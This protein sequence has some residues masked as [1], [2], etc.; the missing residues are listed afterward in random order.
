M[1]GDSTQRFFSGDAITELPGTE[2]EIKNIAS[3]AQD[4]QLSVQKY[5]Y[6]DA[7][8]GRLKAVESPSILHVA[9]HGFFMN[10]SAAASADERGG[11]ANFTSDDLK[12]PLRRSGLL[13]S[14]CK[15]AFSRDKNKLI[16]DEDGILTA[17]EAQNLS[18][19]NTDMVVLSACETGLGEVKNGEGVYGLQR[20]FQTA[21]AKSVLMSLWTVSDQATQELMTEF[22]MQWFSLKD[23]KLAFRQA[24]L[25]LKKKYPDPFYWGAF[26]LVGD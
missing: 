12:N 4:N 25:N 7:T 17:D 3:I 24:Q 19:D 1:E 9:T 8:E 6:D 11:F 2:I 13:F 18:L 14:Y 5:L 23:K 20:A 10:E 26:V 22:Y 21:G 16:L 15:Q